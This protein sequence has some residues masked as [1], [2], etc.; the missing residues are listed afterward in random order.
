VSSRPDAR[1]TKHHLSGRRVSPSGHFSSTSGRLSVLDQ[2]QISF[3]VPRKGRSINR[4]NDV[5]SCPNARL[6]KARIAIQI[7]PFGHLTAMVR[8]RVHQRR[9]LNRKFNRLDDCLSWS[10]R[11]HC[12]YGNCVLKNCHPDAQS[13]IRKLLAADVR[14][15]RRGY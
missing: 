12:R 5:V 8:T 9:K 6:L 10:G 13:L 11:A 14:P 1:R 7:S 3:Q 15:F 2:F 4:P